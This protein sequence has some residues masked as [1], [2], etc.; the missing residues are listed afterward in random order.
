MILNV[1]H[2]SKLQRSFILGRLIYV[3]SDFLRCG[4]ADGL[5]TQQVRTLN[6]EG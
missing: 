1:F 5:S 2:V 3:T 6:L 4:Y